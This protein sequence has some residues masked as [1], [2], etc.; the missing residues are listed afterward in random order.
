MHLALEV[1]RC[2][3]II[4]SEP[5]WRDSHAYDADH[6]QFHSAEWLHGSFRQPGTSLYSLRAPSITSRLLSDVSTSQ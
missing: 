5:L 4:Y 3:R 1:H 6:R 2:L